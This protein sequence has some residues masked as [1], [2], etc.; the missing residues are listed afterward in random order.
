MNN[1]MGK[2]KKKKKKLLLCVKREVD[3]QDAGGAKSL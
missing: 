3:V 2:V 1:I